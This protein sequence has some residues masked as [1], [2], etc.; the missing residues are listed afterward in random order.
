MDEGEEMDHYDFMV[1]LICEC[2]HDE[3][4]HWYYCLAINQSSVVN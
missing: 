2:G 4:S 1:W 3:F